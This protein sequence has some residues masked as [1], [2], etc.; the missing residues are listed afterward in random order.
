MT[1][2]NP[3]V[4]GF[5]DPAT[6]TISYVVHEVEGHK[7]A[8]IDPV[9]DYDPRT[10]RTST[11]SATRLLDYVRKHEL[12]VDWILETHAHAD[13]L[14]AAQELRRELG[15]GVAIGEHICDV[16]AHFAH[17]FEI[18]T[19]V[20]AD[21]RQF[22]RLFCEGDTFTIGTLQG[23]VMYT[24]GHTPACVTYVIGD[25]AFV[26]DTLFM[27]DYGTARTDFPGGEARLLYRSIQRILQLPPATRLFMCHDYQPGG[28]EPYWETTVGDQRRGNLMVKDGISEDEFVRM[29]K[30]RDATLAAPALILP[31]LQVNI[32]GG[33]L[34]PLSANGVRYL[35]LPLNRLGRSEAS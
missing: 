32:R 27:P 7:A 15:A 30:A 16:Q 4:Q 8:I 31:S 3:V 24:P 33:R 26:G 28:R 20:K 13:H 34:P 35:K 1:P 17:F 29:R 9:L 5:F 19:E 2:N 14:S 6:A 10:A 11:R 12:Q 21:G 22:D 25:A 18:E 23:R